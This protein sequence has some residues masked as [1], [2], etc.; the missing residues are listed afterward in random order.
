MKLAINMAEYRSII[1]TSI[2]EIN[3]FS[4]LRSIY[5]Y[6]NYIYISQYALLKCINMI[7]EK[8]NY[9]TDIKLI[10]L[11]RKYFNLIINYYIIY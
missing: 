5:I 10:T 9:K 4:L 11:P 6:I 7:T 8:Y 2:L 3:F 1:K